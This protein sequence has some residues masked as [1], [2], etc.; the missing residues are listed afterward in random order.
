MKLCSSCDKA[1][2]RGNWQCPQCSYEPK[3]IQ[4]HLAFAPELATES[5][6]FEAEYFSRLAKLEAGNFWFRSRNRL[7]IWAMLRYFP[8]AGNF[9]EI[10]CGTGFVLS[11]IKEAFP[12][13]SLSGSEIFSEGLNFAAERLPGVELLQMDARRIPF[14]E[15]FDVIG[16]FDVLEHVKEDA[17]VLT[18]MHHATRK[19]GGILLTVPQHSSL[20]SEVDEFAR[21]ARRYSARD[22]KAKVERA[23]FETV[24]TTSFVSLLLP[25]MFISRLK[26]R[27]SNQDYDPSAEF[28][29]SGPINSLLEQVL[30]V[31]RAMIRFGV[32]FPIGG[33]LLLI[34]RRI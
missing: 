3:K 24:R 6:G 15:E 30:N 21:H 10:G 22:L 33:S 20:W 14:H 11:G 8:Q 32:S 31:E 34:A 27:C 1:F 5:E 13:L 7:L 17:E 29:I 26:Q 16:A 2:D 19:G 23:G 18:Q 12:K 25:L 28:E 4:G 9:L